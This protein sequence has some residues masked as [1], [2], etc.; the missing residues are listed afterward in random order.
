MVFMYLI[1]MFVILFFYLT[2]LPKRILFN[3]LYGDKGYISKYYKNKLKRN[4]NINF[5]K[6]FRKN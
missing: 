3:K 1:Q 2:T 4:R 6:P 5:V